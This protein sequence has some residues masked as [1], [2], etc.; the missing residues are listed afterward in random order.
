MHSIDSNQEVCHQA[1]SRKRE[2]SL[3]D[4]G[5]TGDTEVVTGAGLSSVADLTTSHRVYALNLSTGVMKLKPVRGL[6]RI[7]YQ[8][9]L[10]EIRTNR[11]NIRVMPDHRIPYTT[12]ATSWPRV[13]RAGDLWDRYQYRFINEWQRL[14]RKRT[15]VID[16]TELLQPF[17]FEYELC[18]T[19]DEHGH[20]VRSMLPDGCEPVRRYRE[21]GYGFDSATF[22]KYQTIIEELATSVA[23]RSG[24]GFRARPYRFDADDFYRTDWLVRH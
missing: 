6:E 24:P 12:K 22:K 3:T 15:E 7:E 2:V 23:I 1:H 19:F 5:F 13:L 4:G 9:Q 16:L 18:A 20:T 10:V 14:P 17:D 21:L 11:S 8:G